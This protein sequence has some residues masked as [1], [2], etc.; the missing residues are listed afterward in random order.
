MRIQRENTNLD[1]PSEYIAD[2]GFS[3]EA[4]QGCPIMA[5][6]RVA[7]ATCTQL[8]DELEKLRH[9][10]TALSKQCEGLQGDL[11][12]IRH[13]HFGQSS[14]KLAPTENL[15]S[16]P[17]CLGT[18]DNAEGTQESITTEARTSDEE[19]ESNPA[20]DSRSDSESDGSEP[21]ASVP[22]NRRKRGG[23]NGHAGHGRT[24]PE[25]LP[26]VIEKLALSPEQTH[27]GISG[28]AYCHARPQISRTVSIEFRPVLV[29]YER[30]T[31][32]ECRFAGQCTADMNYCAH[33]EAFLAASEVDQASADVDATAE[34]SDKTKPSKAKTRFIT[35]ARKPQVIPKGKFSHALLA[36]ILILRFG[37]SIPVER[38]LSLLALWGLVIPK[39]SIFGAFKQMQPAI[40]PLYEALVEESRSDKQW[41]VDETGWMSF[42]KNPDKKGFLS[43][44][45][46]FVSKRAVVYI[47]HGSRSSAV[48]LGHLGTTVKGILNCDRF[49]AYKK[50]AKLI[51]GLVLAFCWAHTRRDY[52]NASVKHKQLEPWAALWI[53]RIGEIY[54]LNDHRIQVRHDAEALGKAQKRLEDAIAKMERDCRSELEDPNLH[55]A[56][57]KVLKS[58]LNH[59]AGLT[60]FVQDVDIPIDNNAA[61]RGMRKPAQARRTSYGTYASWSGEFMAEMLSITQTATLHGLNPQAYLEYYLDEYAKTQGT[62]LDIE[63]LLPWNI[64]ADVLKERNLLSHD[65]PNKATQASA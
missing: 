43:W 22:P 15:V 13:L 56:Q 20:S 37:Y 23:Q 60:V 57:K 48:P 38:V 18:L 58:M 4:I 50:L 65:H 54:H 17:E 1:L 9:E 39:G 44:I 45:W 6:L 41:C 28:K 62:D 30:E 27:C 5:R 10:N 14:E 19:S 31:V 51:P 7:E 25:G 42:I 12:H 47:H 46:I 32:I 55:A 61:E 11:N 34:L 36:F 64:P 26:V 49:S 24:I 16:D 52:L 35:A 21:K 2:L 8:A 29:H 63:A 53:E 33:K 59:W 40:K 3:C